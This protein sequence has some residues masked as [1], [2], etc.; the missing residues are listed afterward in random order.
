MVMQVCFGRILI[1]WS[2]ETNFILRTGRHAIVC[3]FC[4][5]FWIPHV[6]RAKDG[7]A[8]VACVADALNLLRVE[9]TIQMV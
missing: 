5:D 7:E 6:P 9:P 1:M 8:V 2:R 4:L 3:F